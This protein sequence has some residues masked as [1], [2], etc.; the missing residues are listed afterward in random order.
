M[1][2]LHP[3][4]QVTA[5]SPRYVSEF[6][7]TGPACEDNCCTGWKVTLDKKTFNAYRQSRD[8][9]L[10]ERFSTQLKRNRA[11]DSDASYAQIALAPETLACPFIEEKL[12]AI[13]RDMGE[14]KL[15]NTCATYPRANRSIAGRH[16]QALALSCPEAA[17]LALLSADALDFVEGPLRLR[18]DTVEAIK[19]VHGCTVEQMDS[20]RVFCLQLLRTDGLEL[21]QKLAVLALFCE[22]FTVLVKS[23]SHGRIQALLD[24]FS[25]MVS[26]GATAEALSG[27]QPDY[28]AQATVFATL[29]Q[30]RIQGQMSPVQVAVQTAVARGLGADPVTNEVTAKQLIER[31]KTGVTNLPL[32]TQEVPFLLQNYLLNEMFKECFPFGEKSP[33]EHMLSLISRYGLLRLMLG[34]QCSDEA[35]LPTPE[36]MVRTVQVA[37]R[38]YQHDRAYAQAV[39]TALH[40]GGWDSLENLYRFLRT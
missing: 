13:Q 5:L 31:Y 12:C 22:Q 33:H 40:E 16:E 38:K 15:S 28:A 27:M 32:A 39:N 19:S 26:T 18:P 10:T 2:I 8:P 34:A 11:A 25:T 4:K 37:C 6:S 17:R 35:T 30:L 3:T 29:W 36:Q 1:N 23:A 7:C 9:H 24:M 20:V 21:W 14:D